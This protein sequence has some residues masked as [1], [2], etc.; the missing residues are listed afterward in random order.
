M[1]KSLRTL[2]VLS[3]LGAV[4]APVFAAEAT[5][6]TTP[7]AK[8]MKHKKVRHHKKTMKKAAKPVTTPEAK[9]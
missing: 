6:V 1:K 3:F 2:L 4:C 5:P 9:K 8:V 7:A